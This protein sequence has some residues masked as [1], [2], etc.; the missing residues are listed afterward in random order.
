MDQAK[1]KAI[2]YW[3]AG[4]ILLL[5]SLFV[6]IAIG[7]GRVGFADLWAWIQGSSDAH[8]SNIL[9][10]VRVPRVLLASL[11]GFALSMS[12]VVFQGVL[13]N[14]L[15]DPYILGISGGAALTTLFVSA[16]TSGAIWAA[17]W[18]RPVAAF[19]GA[20]VSLGILFLFHNL[21]RRKSVVTLL[22]I[23]VV[24]NAIAGAGIL[25]LLFA[26]SS[27]RLQSE[28]GFLMGSIDSRAL[29]WLF[30]LALLIGIGALVTF[31]L[32]HRLNLLTLG[33]NTATT[34][35]VRVER[36]TWFVLLAA[37]WMTACA[38]AFCGLIG[39]VGLM[40]PHIM[41][42]LVGADHRRLLPA[43]A[44]AGA[45][46]LPLADTI[47]RTV[48]APTELPVGVITTLLGGPAFLYILMRHLRRAPT[49][50]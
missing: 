21:L 27:G 28:F 29:P 15:A 24:M 37:S 5:A 26:A 32:S 46:F 18:L 14:P 38:V 6:S 31:A 40:I 50:P 1:S 34:L 22:L 45:A 17:G 23:G 35:G 13:R 36:T 49:L 41:R 19:V 3:L 2:G 9:V 42:M 7:P 43:A 10:Q 8:S 48:M 16:L 33:E 12:G 25:L 11:A 4:I 39:F 44:L 20:L 30:M 47:A